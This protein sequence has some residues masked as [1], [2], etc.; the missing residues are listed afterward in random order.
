[1]DKIGAEQPRRAIGTENDSLVRALAV[2]PR[3]SGAPLRGC[4]A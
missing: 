1:M 4:R 2:K 3:A